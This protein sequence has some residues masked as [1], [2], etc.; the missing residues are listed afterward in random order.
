MSPRIPRAPSTPKLKIGQDF[1]P[2]PGDPDYQAMQDARRGQTFVPQRR[3]NF[4]RD[5]MP[6]LVATG[7]GFGMGVVLAW[8]AGLL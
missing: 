1:M 2:M 6:A 3:S 4:R 7:I 8:S 5:V